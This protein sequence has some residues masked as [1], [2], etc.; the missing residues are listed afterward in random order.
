MWSPA[1]DGEVEVESGVLLLYNDI[2]LYLNL[3]FIFLKWETIYNQKGG[4]AAKKSK[5]ENKRGT[6]EEGAY[7]WIL[8]EANL[9]NYISGRQLK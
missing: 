2:V 5:E 4:E 8:G 6:K 9:W 7:T 1:L 3:K